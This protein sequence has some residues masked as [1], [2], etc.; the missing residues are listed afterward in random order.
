MAHMH[1]VLERVL[2]AFLLRCGK[3]YTQLVMVNTLLE[4]RLPNYA[5]TSL[6]QY[7]LSLLHHHPVLSLSWIMPNDTRNISISYLKIQTNQKQ[8]NK[9]K[10]SLK[11]T[12]PPAS[13]LFLSGS[14]SYKE[15]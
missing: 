8:Q 5:R 15:N 12:F 11:P 6:L 9:Q 1:Y 13:T 14:L 3:E 7:P 10:P 4:R 2:S